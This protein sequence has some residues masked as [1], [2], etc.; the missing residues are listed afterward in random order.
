MT[1]IFAIFDNFL[2]L[3]DAEN[4]KPGSRLVCVSS[5]EVFFFLCS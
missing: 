3:I 2:F 5:C 1:L 4:Q